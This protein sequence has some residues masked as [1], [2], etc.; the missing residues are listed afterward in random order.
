MK[1]LNTVSFCT[2]APAF[3]VRPVPP[4]L[5]S[6][7]ELKSYMDTSLH[8]SRPPTGQSK[9]KRM[10]HFPTNDSEERIHMANSFS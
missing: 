6:R 9:V 7:S 2:E 3:T 10:T 8:G 4:E 5:R 1:V